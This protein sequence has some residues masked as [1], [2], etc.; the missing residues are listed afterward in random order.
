MINLALSPK[1]LVKEEYLLSIFHLS[2]PIWMA[3]AFT[4]ELK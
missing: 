1:F 3:I 2:H 4:V